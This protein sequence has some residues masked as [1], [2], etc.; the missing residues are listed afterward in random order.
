[1]TTNYTLLWA[2]L[3]LPGSL[4]GA[5]CTGLA[6][7]SL[8]AATI[9]VAEEVKSGAANGQ[10]DL[11]PFCRVAGVLKP[12]VDSEIR[13]ETWM[14]LAGWNSKFQGIGNG[15]FA[16]SITYAG[17][18]DAV[19]NGYAAASTDTGHQAS[20]IDAGWALGHPEKVI[21][22]GHRAIHVTAVAGKAITT[23]FYGAKPTRSYFNA[24]SNGGRQALMEAQRYPE[25]YDG[26]IA[27]A[28]ANNWTHLLGLAVSNMQATASNAT[29]YIPQS[30][31]A[32]IQTAALAACDKADA[33]EDGV[34]GN[35]EGC[36]FDPGALACSGAESDKC[37]T[38]D[39]LK[40]LRK[41]YDGYRDAKGKLLYPGYSPGGEAEQGGWGPWITGNAPEKSLLFAFGT[42]FYRNMVFSD[43]N[44]DYRKFT[45]A[46]FKTAVAKTASMLD[47][48]DPDLRR[49]KARGGKLILYHGWCDAAIPAQAVIDYYQSVQ[50]KMGAKTT[51]EFVR[52]FMVP[53]MQHCG[54]GAG[55][56]SFGQLG[57]AQADARTNI[58]AALEKWV[59]TG[60]APE[61]I[62]AVRKTAGGV[63]T[64]PLCAYPKVARYKGSGSTDE[65][66]NFE[67]AAPDAAAAAI[68]PGGP[69]GSPDLLRMADGRKVSTANEWRRLRRPEVVRL[70]EANQFGRTVAGRGKVV[71]QA[72]ELEK[73][74]LG[75]KAVRKQTTVLWEGRPDGARGELLLYL[76]AGA[77]GR[78]PVFLGLNFGG[79]HTVH[80]DR[81]IR[82]P[83]V[84]S[85]RAPFG[86]KRAEESGRGA[87]AQAWQVE[88]ILARG[89]GLATMYYGD[90]EPDFNGGLEHGVRR[91]FLAAGKTEF[92]ADEWGAI[93]AWAWGLSRIADYLE[94][95]RDVDARHIAL[96]GHSRLG[97][98]ALW[99]G[100]QDERFG[101]VI[102]NDSGEGGAAMSRHLVGEDVARINESFPHWFCRNY[103][104]YAK[105]ESELPVDAHM[106]VALMAP[107]P[108]YVASAEEDQW[109]DPE[110]EFMSAAAAGTVYELLGKKGLGVREMPGIH[111]PVMGTVGY[112]IRA[113]KH[114]VTAYDWEQYLKFADL[115]WK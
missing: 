53:G 50:K 33:V 23:A 18:A 47:S 25:D 74:A 91:Q 6:K 55:P 105:R 84:W 40:A 104:K 97:K 14:P 79:N 30:K 20:G 103:R 26:I 101:I 107:R 17:L 19:R 16:G 58:S 56:N 59:E 1:M 70:F 86:K 15:G 7:L 66:A 42:G 28:P 36:R 83:E 52:L 60:A 108:V 69:L 38:S 51:G 73:D 82:L 67:C 92:A 93:G 111:Q 81:G 63:R 49:F 89:Y 94:S 44:W 76:P 68:V 32:A 31:L 99:A 77:K 87:D 113:G 72:A 45:D 48:T 96:M 34:V 114:A 80:A 10:K 110:G 85:R 37:L 39:Q 35:P 88:T 90:I 22:F 64:R 27:G 4:R 75:S 62:I 106:L 71:F 78:V 102:S 109:A 61:E 13:F 29:A 54:G 3:A 95:D 21:D 57:V 24:C 2:V 112:H 46:D 41:L 12:S 100:A 8:P 9:A 11:P 5:D 43:P 115:H 65:A 98:T